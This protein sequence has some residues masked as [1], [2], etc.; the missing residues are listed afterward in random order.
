MKTFSEIYED[1]K[2]KFADKSNLDIEP[3]T[4]IDF[5]MLSSAEALNEAY[6]EIENNK[7]P[8]IFTKLTGEDLDNMGFGYNCPRMANESD[9]SYRYRLMNW[10]LKS[11]A[12]NYTAIEMALMNMNYASY[13]TYVPLTEGVA[14]ATAYIIPKSYDETTIANA[15]AEAQERLKKVCSP[16]TY[17]SYVIPEA[18]PVRIVAYINTENGDIETIKNNIKKKVADYINNIAI[19]DFLELGEI[20]KIGINENGVNYFNVIQ[21]YINNKVT[22]ALNIL[23]KIESKFVFD[24]IIWWTVE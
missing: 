7:N 16:G 14:T 8:H 15:I 12:S 10:L 21:L 3:G 18:I 23:Q 4:V 1:L 24:D 17:I 20:N 22:N 2:K 9:E 11:E 13:V 5:Y 19:G 6:Q